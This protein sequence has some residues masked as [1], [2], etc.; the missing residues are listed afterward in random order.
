LDSS[1]VYTPVT[2]TPER[3]LDWL[4]A[5]ESWNS[6]MAGSGSSQNPDRDPPFASPFPSQEKSKPGNAHILIVEDNPADVFLIQETIVAAGITVSVHVVKDGEEATRFLDAADR[7]AAAPCPALVILDINLPRKNG[8]EVLQ[9]LRH[10]S[11]CNAVPVIVVSTSDAAKDRDSVLVNGA[12]AYF[13]KP[14][15]YDEFMKLADL[16]C[17]WFP[18]RPEA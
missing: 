10:T 11:R 2:N 3:V 15:A 14:S 1:N 18:K 8:L 12:S 13:H 6:T 7:D 17:E 4:F 16:I 5:S 9:H